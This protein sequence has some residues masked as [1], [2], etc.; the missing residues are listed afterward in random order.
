MKKLL[1]TYS[2]L[3]VALLMSCSKTTLYEFD[4]S[5][6]ALYSKVYMPLA[7]REIEAV[8]ISPGGEP[9]EFEYSAYLG[10]PHDAEG[11]LKI[12]FGVDEEKVDAYNS[13]RNVDYKLLPE[14]AYELETAS[15]ITSGGRNTETLKL[16]IKPEANL[17]WEEVTYVLPLSIT[18]AGGKALNEA[19]STVYFLF[20]LQFGKVRI[21]LANADINPLAINTGNTF[22]FT[23]YLDG[24]VNPEDD[25]IVSFDVNADKVAEYNSEHGTNYILLPE[26][27]YDLPVEATLGAQSRTTADI[28]VNFDHNSTDLVA[29]KMYILPISIVEASGGAMINDQ[30]STLY[31]VVWFSQLNAIPAV[32]MGPEWGDV[33]CAGPGG[34]FYIRDNNLDIVVY[35][36]NAEG[37]FT[38]NRIVGVFWDLTESMYYINETEMVARNEPYWAGLFAFDLNANK[39]LIARDPWEAFWLG[40][41]W[42]QFV[43]VPYKHLLLTIDHDGKMWS[44]PTMTFVSHPKNEVGAGFSGYRKIEAFKDCLLALSPD[45]NL[46]AYPMSADGVP[47]AKIQIGE[48]WDIYTDFIVSGDDVLA[49]DDHGIVFRYKDFD[50]GGNYYQLN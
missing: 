33:Y 25:I 16:L 18:D 13:M 7:E 20:D 36:P 23:A 46:W 4:G 30:L 22:V 38:N 44:Q 35:E 27:A 47:G 49:V 19:L 3:F 24:P 14:G 32:V 45:G 11:D 1:L 28:E 10:G 9:L 5:E 17:P 6:V 42:D 50:L 40:D 12:T 2:T 31:V 37:I 21:P 43:I 15:V 29:E 48:G 8:V 39:E 26:S 41:F 34:S